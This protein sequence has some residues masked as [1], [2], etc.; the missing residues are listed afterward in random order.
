[1]RGSAY[2]TLAILLLRGLPA[3]A[4]PP[5]EPTPGAATFN[6]FVRSTPIGFEQIELLRSPSGWVI[7]SR[8]DLSRPIDLENRLFEV[9]Y[10]EQWRPQTLAIDA[11]RGAIPFSFRATFAG[12]AATTEL[13]EAG[14]HFSLTT[15]VPPDAVV[16]PDYFF[17]AYEALAVRLASA[18]PG[19]EIPIYAAPRAVS[20]ARVDQIIPQQIDT[21]AAVVDARVYRLSF[22]NPDGPLTV[23]VWTDSGHRLL[24]V[25]I[26]EAALDVA[27]EDIVS[28]GARVLGVS[29]SGDD[30]ARVRAE[31]F[32]LAATVT[33]PVDHPR[34]SAGWPAVLLVPGP[35]AGDRDG[36]LA[37]MPVLGQ[38]AGALAD[39]GVLVARYDI[40]G[41]GQSGGR[42]ESAD[43]EAY[44]DDARA[45]VR[46]LDD[47]DDVDRDRITVLGYAEGGWIAMVVARRERKV[48]NLVLVGTPERRAPNWCSSSSV[49]C[50]TNSARQGRNGRRGSTCSS[51][52][53]T[54][55]STAV[56]GTGFR[57][58]CVVRPTH[59]GFT[60]FWTSI[61]PTPSGGP[62]NRSSS[63]AARWTPRSVPITP[64]GWRILAEPEA[65]TALWSG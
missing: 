31:G 21:G 49:R 62:D 60:I 42:S 25:T 53:M 61:R 5:V 41:V 44:A 8:G 54:R 45:M 15:Q 6:V 1:M 43:V 32:V 47:R 19:D 51:E 35:G 48:D 29:H 13:D 64:S 30:D 24:R 38:I 17:A 12:N 23:E 58:R 56:R 2:C 63:F 22:P 50:S 57:K 36:T 55:C 4:Q 59:P 65:G 40:R 33:T 16:L 26:P 9:E 34:P 28:M 20:G 3:A 46:Y 52:F 10:D 39:A 14:Q 18:R 11:A 37:G 27:R 7:R